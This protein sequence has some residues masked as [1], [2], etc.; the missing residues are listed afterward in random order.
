VEG[1]WVAFSAALSIAH[2]ENNAVEAQQADTAQQKLEAGIGDDVEGGDNPK[3]RYRLL[4]DGEKI[5]P[6]DYWLLADTETWVNVGD[7]ANSWIGAIFN[8][9]FHHPCRRSFRNEAEGVDQA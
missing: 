6:S 2:S 7:K 1:N 3:P 5:L 8:G 4:T 9:S